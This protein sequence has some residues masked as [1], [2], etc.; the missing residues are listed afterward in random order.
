MSFDT[1]C[2]FRLILCSVY[3]LLTR[4]CSCVYDVSLSIKKSTEESKWFDI[5]IVFYIR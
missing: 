1:Y 2:I 5:R 3:I 4:V